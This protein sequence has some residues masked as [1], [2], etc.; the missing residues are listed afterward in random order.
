MIIKMN[1]QTPHDNYKLLIGSVVPR[2][3]AFVTSINAEGIV[4]AAPF[5]FFNIVNDNPPMIMFSCGRHADGTLKDTA[6]N[7]L[8]NQEFVAHITD[9]DNIEAINHTS[10]NAPE[11]V[12]ELGLAG[13]TAVPGTMVAVPRVQECPVAME[14]RLAQHVP[15]GHFDVF[16]GEVLSFYVRDDLIQNGRIDIGKLKPVSR[17]A[18]LSYS[19]IGRIFDL[20]RP[21]YEER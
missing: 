8:A 12:S 7:I 21:V 5:S 19:A 1:E 13:L 14:C 3:V 17:L 10:I 18:G 16:I 6:R 11:S 20:E 9:E 15:L 4:N 2:P